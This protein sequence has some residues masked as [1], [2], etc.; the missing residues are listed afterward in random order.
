MMLMVLMTRCN[1]AT[2]YFPLFPHS[3]GANRRNAGRGGHRI[4]RSLPDGYRAFAMSSS[5]RREGLVYPQKICEL[6]LASCRKIADKRE[7]TP[8]ERRR[9]L[10][11]AETE[12][13]LVLLN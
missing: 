12:E 5:A 10:E 6:L 9:T 11:E 3:I 7:E 8:R 4:L 1:P 2:I 13:E